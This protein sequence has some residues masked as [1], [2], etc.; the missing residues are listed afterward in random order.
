MPTLLHEEHAK[1]I[2]SLIEV[3]TQA[4]DPARA[5]SNHWPSTLDNMSRC[6]MVGAGKASLEMAL[7]LQTLCGDKLVGGTVAVVPERLSRLSEPPH[8]FDVF[9]ASH[10]LPD[11]RNLLASQSI[12]TIARKAEEVDIL[13]ALISGGGSSHLMLPAG[14]LVF[15]DLRRVTALLQRAGAPIR[16]L[17]TVRKH[18]EVLKGGGL[19]RLAYPAQV[20]AFILSDVVGDSLNVIA[21]GPTSPDPTTYADALKVLDY[22]NLHESVP[23]ITSHLEMGARGDIPETLKPGDPILTNVHNILIGNNR[24]VLEAARKHATRSG[25]HVIGFEFGVEGEA[26]IEGLNLAMR[27]HSLLDRPDRPLCYLMGGET[28]VTVHGEGRGG[29]NQE[30]ALAAAIHL[31]GLERVALAAFATDG[32]DGPTDAAGAI[33]TGETCARARALGMDAQEYL[34]NNDSHTFFDRIGSLIRTGPT[35]TNVNDVTMALIY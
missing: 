18:C 23:A 8:G 31:D 29:R 13:V 30:L 9:P 25:W 16:A 33:V 27:V 2:Y 35:G 15:E 6:Y 5:L 19:L 14:E 4:A 3:V 20:W 34:N 21:S 1:H 17:N 10:P 11:E 7:Q 26:R 32:V 12:A 22:Y 24:L 28:S